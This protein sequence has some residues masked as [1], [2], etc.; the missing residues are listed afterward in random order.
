MAGTAW[1][2]AV[3]DYSD[4]PILEC[5]ACQGLCLHYKALQAISNTAWALSVLLWHSAQ[6]LVGL[7]DWQGRPRLTYETQH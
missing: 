2:F 7:H 6:V 3:L 5:I 1:A 4:N